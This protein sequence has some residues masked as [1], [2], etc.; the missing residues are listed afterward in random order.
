MKAIPNPARQRRRVVVDAAIIFV[1]IVLMTQM[2]LL[3][4]TLESYLA[5]HQEVVLP[6]MLVSGVL[7]LACLALYRLVIRLDQAPEPEEES[8]GSGPWDIE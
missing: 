1:V 7:F 6:G 5:G 3:T 2:W 4:A 8:R